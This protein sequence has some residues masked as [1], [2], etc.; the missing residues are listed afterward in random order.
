MI[1]FVC[2]GSVAILAIIGW[3]VF[4]A[5]L[6][7]NE[8]DL[9][10]D[11]CS[12]MSEHRF[13]EI[14][15]QQRVQPVSNMD[16]GIN[17]PSSVHMR[18]RLQP[19]P[20]KG[21]SVN[22]PEWVS[23]TKKMPVIAEHIKYITTQVSEDD[24]HRVEV[25]LSSSATHDG[26]VRY[27]IARIG[28]VLYIKG[29]KSN[30][31]E[32]HTGDAVRSAVFDAQADV[33]S[34]L[35]PEWILSPNINRVIQIETFNYDFGPMSRAILSYQETHNVDTLLV[36]RLREPQYGVTPDQLQNVDESILYTVE[37]WID[38]SGHI[39]ERRYS[40][41]IFHDGIL[42][43]LVFDEVM[44]INVLEPFEL[45]PPIGGVR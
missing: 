26:K 23:T 16:F 37:F 13:Y 1:V 45:E 9:V 40:V 44:T 2:L 39:V 11:A 36:E 38:V 15:Q 25:T 17:A 6:T 4:P 7:P 18:L 22:T 3:R 24:T 20:D 5:I 31:W 30:N 12:R 34:L 42:R 41:H 43:G 33:I 21:A 10:Q 14:G 19:G 35:C 32:I 29:S 8:S 27:E 28:D